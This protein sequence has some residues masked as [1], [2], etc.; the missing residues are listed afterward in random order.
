MSLIAICCHDTE[1]ND[2]TKYTKE[3]LRSLK[4]TVDW[5]KHVIYIID[6]NSCGETKAF[7]KDFRKQMDFAVITLDTNV[8]TAKGINM[9]LIA[10]KPNQMC[11]KMDNDVVVHQSVWVEEMEQIIAQNAQIGIL[12]LKRDDVYGN[13]T[14]D[15]K[16]LYGDDIMGTCTAFNPLLLD[17]VGYMIQPSEYGYDDVLMSVRSLAAGFKNAFLPHIKITHLDDG[18]NPYCDWKKKLAGEH[19]QEISIACQMYRDG[20]LDYYYDGN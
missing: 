8:G 10:R 2:R 1:E 3:T 15:G 16:L 17:K 7:L 18:L 13:F 4:E 14:A 9:A 11:I 12:G 6:N 19:L 5:K 20:K